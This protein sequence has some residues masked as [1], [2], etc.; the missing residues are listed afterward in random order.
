MYSVWYVCVCVCVYRCGPSAIYIWYISDVVHLK[1]LWSSLLWMITSVDSGYK[2][3]MGN[4]PFSE[5]ALEQLLAA[6][7]S[8]S[9]LSLSLRNFNFSLCLS[10]ERSESRHWILPLNSNFKSMNCTKIDRSSHHKEGLQLALTFAAQNGL[11]LA[12]DNICFKFMA[13]THLLFL[14]HSVYVYGERGRERE[15]QRNSS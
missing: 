15:R 5:D 4:H 9:L 6:A 8:L 3:L 13:L 14:V 7:I 11:S 10:F 12:S 1:R 2:S